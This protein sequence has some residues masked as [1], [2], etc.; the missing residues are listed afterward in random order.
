[1]SLQ[2]IT[3]L[4][5]CKQPLD[6]RS[7]LRFPCKSNKLGSR[8]DTDATHNTS[9]SYSREAL[10]DHGDGGRKNFSL[11]VGG[12]DTGRPGSAAYAIAVML[13][14]TTRH[15]VQLPPVQAWRR[16]K[17]PHLLMQRCE[18][19]SSFHLQCRNKSTGFSEKCSRSSFFFFFFFS[20]AFQLTGNI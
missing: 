4:H 1:L 12:D 16:R 13:H 9:S 5:P 20:Y 6:T 3:A 15:H 11:R 17:T 2:I 7:G 19:R 14:Y 18:H 10:T 8:D